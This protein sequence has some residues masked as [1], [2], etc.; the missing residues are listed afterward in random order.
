MTIRQQPKKPTLAGFLKLSA[1]T[2]DQNWHA[3][4]N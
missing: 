3:Y 4:L 2:I 1:G